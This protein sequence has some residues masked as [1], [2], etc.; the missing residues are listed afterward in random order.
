MSSPSVS[1]GLP[2][3]NGEVRIGRAL[4]SILNQDFMDFEVIISD[5]ASTDNT[6]SVCLQYAQRDSRIRYFRNET[7]IGVNPNH[8][9]VFHLSTGTYFAWF[10]DDL[11]YLPGMLRRCVDVMKSAPSSV[12]LIYPKCEMIFDQQS[13]DARSLASFEARERTPH[14]RL[15]TVIR[16]V[17]M[18][19]QFFGLAKREL[20]AKTKLNG[21]YASSDYVLL[22]ELALLGE[23]WEV[24]ET[25]IKRRI[26]FDRGTAAV[27]RDKKAWSLW[28]G[29]RKEGLKNALANRERLAL[30]YLLAAWRS[31]IAPI[32]K[33]KCLMCIL[34]T[35][36]SRTSSTA[37]AV[38]TFA[39]PWRW[40]C[41]STAHASTRQIQ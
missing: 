17:I 33:V 9:R 5:N 30:E 13:L 6:R 8:D 39:S 32:E 1:I 19:N 12:A 14:G 2:V 27:F 36:Y 23:L 15:K 24:P 37:D 20:L 26:D 21:L 31:P 4:D 16:N 34:P 3:F 25:L 28:S 40:K 38:L 29:A 18:V 7:N 41:F 11:E 10:A 35:Y 22:A